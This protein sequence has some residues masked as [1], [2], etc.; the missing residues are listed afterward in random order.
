[1]DPGLQ[2][3]SW[4]RARGV[5]AACGR[6]GRAAPPAGPGPG[7]GRAAARAAAPTAVCASRRARC[8]P[9]QTCGPRA[10][11]RCGAAF[12]RRRVEA[13]GIGEGRRVAVGGRRSTRSTRSPRRIARAAERRR[14]ASRS[15][16]RRPPPAPG[17]ATPRSRWAAAPVGAHQREL[18]RRREQVQDRVGD[19]ALGRL[20]A[21]E[22][23]HRGV[24]DDL[25][26]LEP[27]GVAA[28]GG[29]QRGPGARSSTGSMAAR[30]SAKAAAAGVGNLA[31]GRHFGHRGDDR[32]VPAEHG[33]GVG[34]AQA[35]A[36]ASRS[37]AASG[38]AKARRSSAAPSG[39]TP[40]ISRSTS[41]AT[42]SV[43]RSRTACEAK[44]ARERRAVAPV[45]VAVEREHA[46]ADDLRRSRS[47]G[48]RR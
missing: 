28:G 35:R 40:S 36:R 24:G 8:I 46:R 25:A 7:A 32:V 30:R 39:S 48:R 38:P 5:T 6:R 15:G 3:G 9:M 41:A 23:H 21:A 13:V 1:M 22:E 19:H 4:P 34:V 42:T 11:A 47:A 45:L 10:K 20:D 16:R 12:A 37:A 17:A 31:A 2:S 33:G 29:E 18:R 27:A 44:R 26:P 14:R 43:K